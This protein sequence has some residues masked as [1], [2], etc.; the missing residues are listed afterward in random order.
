VVKRPDREA[1]HS[2]PPSGQVRNAWSYTSTPSIRL[3]GVV[4]SW[5]TTFYYTDRKDRLFCTFSIKDWICSEKQSSLDVKML[6]HYSTCYGTDR[7]Y[8]RHARMLPNR[9][10]R[11]AGSL[12]RTIKLY[13]DK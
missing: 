6:R 12:N 7:S 8:E 9:H 2:P 5:T 10:Y 4:L 3:H 11:Y 1:D 13:R